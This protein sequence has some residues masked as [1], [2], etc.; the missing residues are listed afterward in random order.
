MRIRVLSRAAVESGGAIGA[1]GL[2]SIRGTGDGDEPELALAI[3]QA[4]RG[5]SA[6]MLRL[7]HDVIG[8]PSYGHYVG[9]SIGQVQEAID[10]GRRIRDGGVL[11]DGPVADPLIAVHCEHGKSRS[12][13]I[14]LVLL[15]DDLGPGGEHD[16]V[17]MLMRADLEGR[18][19]PNPLTISL[20]DACLFRY[21]QLDAALGEASP[22]Y[23][24]WR[25][26]WKQIAAS[27]DAFWEQTARIMRKNSRCGGRP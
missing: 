4:I 20:T 13:A 15:A 5:E 23:R 22:R 10:F 16:A 19:H 12:S 14:G 24:K 18:M 21:G 3:A 2:I 8:M 26:L 17:N 11:F 27:P 1:D 6:R 25:D 7:V 9:P